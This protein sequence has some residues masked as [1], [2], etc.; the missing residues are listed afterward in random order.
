M[1]LLFSWTKN[2]VATTIYSATII[3][4]ILVLD[5]CI[6]LKIK[7]QVNEIITWQLHWNGTHLTDMLGCLLSSLI[8]T[9]EIFYIKI[10]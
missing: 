6:I 9:Y 8:F 5:S 7:L 4:F 1:D 10:R 3:L 2:S